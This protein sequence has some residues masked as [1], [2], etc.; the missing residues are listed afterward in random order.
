VRQVRSRLWR[1]VEAVEPDT[2]AKSGDTSCRQR[3]HNGIMLLV[4]VT[5]S[6]TLLSKRAYQVLAQALL[7]HVEVAALRLIL[8]AVCMHT[9]VVLLVPLRIA[10]PQW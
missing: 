6:L 10:I 2:A 3:N 1:T 9:V 5:T 8:E 4:G 7:C